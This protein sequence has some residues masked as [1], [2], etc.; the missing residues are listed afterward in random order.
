MRGDVVG[1]QAL[2]TAP[3]LG[4]ADAARV[5]D[6]VEVE[7]LADAHQLVRQLLEPL[8]RLVVAVDAAAAIVAHGVLEEALLD[9]TRRFLARQA[10]Q[11]LVHLAVQRKIGLERGELLLEPL[12]HLALLGAGMDLAVQAD[13]PAHDVE[14]TADPVEG[15]DHVAERR[16]R[17]E[18][19]EHIARA[20]RL[21][22]AGPRPSFER[23]RVHRGFGRVR[24][25]SSRR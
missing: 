6:D 12:R 19:D 20:L 22:E 10:R 4:D 16:P 21:G 15:Q 14:R 7:F 3:A 5:A 13:R 1:G 23:L 25:Y 8:P 17:R 11:A 2:E 9:R 18:R 24:A